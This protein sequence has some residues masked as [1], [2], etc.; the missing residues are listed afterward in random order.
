M[1]EKL[2]RY[3]ILLPVEFND[4]RSV[5]ADLL[6]RAIKE[7]VDRFGAVSEQPDSVEGHWKHRGRV[8]QDSLS[9]VVVDVD[10]TD[11]NRKWMREFKA[12]WKDHL[13]QVD[14]WL[15]SYRIDVE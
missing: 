12:R 1:P 9:R 6:E 15:I 7:I 13:D 5:P 11:D 10:D 2:R 8:Q 4:G 3:E 14:V